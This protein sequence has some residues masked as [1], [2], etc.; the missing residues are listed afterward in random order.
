[1]LATGILPWRIDLDKDTRVAIFTIL[2]MS[3]E[4]MHRTSE[5]RILAL[6]IHEA[7]LKA[8]VPGCLEAYQSGNDNL[9]AGLT[10]VKSKLSRIVDSSIQRLRNVFAAEA[11]PAIRMEGRAHEYGAHC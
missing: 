9:L 6:R 1:V 8:G 7:L 11:L 3:Q 10:G 4:T 5:A 2:E